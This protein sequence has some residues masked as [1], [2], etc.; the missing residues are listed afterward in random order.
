MDSTAANK[1]SQQ[2]SWEYRRQGSAREKLF[3]ALAAFVLAV[4]GAFAIGVVL[5]ALPNPI[6]AVPLIPC[7]I[8][9]IIFLLKPYWAVLLLVFII[10]FQFMANISGDGTITLP[11]ILMPAVVGVWLLNHL[12]K[13]NARLVTSFVSHPFFASVV[14]FYL[15]LLPSYLNAH[16]EGLFFGF[17]FTKMIP[18]YVIAVMLA[19]TINSVWRLKQ[20]YFTVFAIAYIITGFG[21]IEIFTGQSILSLVGMDYNLVGGGSQGLVSTKNANTEEEAEWIRVASTFLDSNYFCG[22]MLLS[23]VFVLG[24]WQLTKSIIA[25]GAIIGYCL[26]V[27]MNVVATGSRAG[28]VSTASFVGL[29]LLFFNYP[30]KR[31]LV[32]CGAIGVVCIIPFLN[33]ILGDSYRNGISLDAFYDDPRYGIWTTGIEMIKEYPVLGVGFGNYLDRWHNFRTTRGEMKPFLPHN[34][35][36]GLLAESGLFALVFFKFAIAVMAATIML[37]WLKTENHGRKQMIKLIG[38]NLCAFYL[39][40]F[41]TNAIDFEFLWITMGATIALT[42][43]KDAELIGSR[44]L[45]PKARGTT[46]PFLL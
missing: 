1:L 23:L 16:H 18:Y 41:S 27:A 10:P 34:T 21:I 13:K 45:T 44:H 42:K 35:T 31:L 3:F 4:A 6:L 20:F 26:M 8:G 28:L 32:V 43:L 39:F 12:V 46:K 17:L 33:D 29:C 25:R 40:S 7:A 14:L 36:L 2:L 11:K 9:G 15:S 30:L 19:D 38:L 22:F 5:T 37:C 24:I